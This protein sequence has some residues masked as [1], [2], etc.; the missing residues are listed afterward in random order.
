MQSALRLT[1]MAGIQQQYQHQ[2]QQQQ[3]N[4]EARTTIWAIANSPPLSD[5]ASS[6]T[7]PHRRSTTAGAG[8]FNP[9]PHVACVSSSS[10]N[11]SASVSATAFDEFSD[12]PDA[13]KNQGC[14]SVGVD[15]QCLLPFEPAGRKKPKKKKGL[16]AGTD[17]VVMK[18]CLVRITKALEHCALVHIFWGPA[19]VVFMVPKHGVFL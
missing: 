18:K 7:L 4:R 3:H 17:D 10:A 14:M 5:H 12:A 2:H 1:L 6:D 15:V 16:A 19:F 13:M 9:H 11:T 8:S